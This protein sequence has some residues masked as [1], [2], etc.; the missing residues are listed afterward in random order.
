MTYF[1]LLSRKEF[2]NPHNLV[3]LSQ[4]FLNNDSQNYIL[5]EIFILRRMTAV[6]LAPE[7]LLIEI[8]WEAYP[9]PPSKHRSYTKK[10]FVLMASFSLSSVSI[11]IFVISSV[12][13]LLDGGN[14][15][16]LVC[17][18][19]FSQFILVLRQAFPRPPSQYFTSLYLHCTV[20]SI[21]SVKL[22]SIMDSRQFLLMFVI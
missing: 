18:R 19:H 9:I 11:E 16:T 5:L 10:Y 2:P 4:L 3:S 12:N 8:S 22:V 15:V 13:S 21:Q 7:A 6:I 14:R 1:L 17:K 20:K